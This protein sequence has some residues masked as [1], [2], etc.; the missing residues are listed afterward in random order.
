[1]EMDNAHALLL[2]HQDDEQVLW[3]RSFDELQA[4]VRDGMVS[5]EI[6]VTMQSKREKQKGL[7]RKRITTACL[8]SSFL[9][10]G[11]VYA[12]LGPTLLLLSHQVGGASLGTMG[13]VFSA[14][15][16]G[17]LGGSIGGGGVIDRCASNPAVML[18]VIMMVVSLG[19]MAIPFVKDLALMFFVVVLHGIAMGMLDT[20]GNV[21]LIRVWKRDVG[22]YM[23][24]IHFCFG[25]G[26]FLAPLAARNLLVESKDSAAGADCDWVNTTYNPTPIPSEILHDKWYEAASWAWW[27]AA[28][29]AAIVSVC[30]GLIARFVSGDSGTEDMVNTFGNLTGIKPYRTMLIGSSMLFL[31]FYVGVEVAYGGLV[32]S[33]AIEDCLLG[34]AGASDVTS[35]YW[36]SFALGRL[37]AIGLSSL[38]MN[39]ERILGIGLTVA[40]TGILPLLMFPRS[41]PVLWAGTSI[42]GIGMAPSFPA[43]FT[44]LSEHVDVTGRIATF[45]IVAAA[46]GE[47]ALPVITAELMQ[48]PALGVAVFTKAIATFTF[49]AYAVYLLIVCL[50]KRRRDL[51]WIEATRMALQSEMRPMAEIPPQTHTN[52]NLVQRIARE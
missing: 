20:C 46:F 15:S 28:I 38:K 36:G 30:W 50:T 24:I 6:V 37:L 47:M 27:G 14:R 21:L 12:M 11:V 13:M 33:F 16:V 22:T 51:H 3:D 4:S 34:V 18:S 32:Y 29:L 42:F 9:C 39:A 5:P 17:Y 43:A 2:S 48:V 44:V 49:A 31:G 52:P 45:V 7:M 40:V 23:Q 35:A 10:L 41:T 19:A 25:F 1:M 8:A 26:A